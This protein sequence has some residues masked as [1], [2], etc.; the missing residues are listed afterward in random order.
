MKPQPTARRLTVT[1]AS[2]DRKPTLRLAGKW[3]HAAG[4]APG[5]RVVVDTSTRGRL[6][7]E[8]EE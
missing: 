8:V 7:I 1:D 6:V 5:A 4:F 2:F 3:L